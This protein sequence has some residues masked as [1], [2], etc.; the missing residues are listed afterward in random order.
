MLLLKEM[1]LK[2]EKGFLGKIVTEFKILIEDLKKWR[3]T[4]EIWINVQEDHLQETPY[5]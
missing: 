2:E 3:V 1:W 4:L 5:K